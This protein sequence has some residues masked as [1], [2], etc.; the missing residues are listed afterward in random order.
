MSD[1]AKS[2]WLNTLIAKAIGKILYKI[3]CKVMYVIYWCLWTEEDFWWSGTGVLCTV[4]WGS[5]Q[6]IYILQYAEWIMTTGFP[7]SEKTRVRVEK[8]DNCGL[9]S[10]SRF[11]WV[12]GKS[13]SFRLSPRRSTRCLY[14]SYLPLWYRFWKDYVMHIRI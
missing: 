7:S 11:G 13:V 4:R 14:R 8:K 10:G 3:L 1:F 12:S 6:H 9:R 5:W 2:S